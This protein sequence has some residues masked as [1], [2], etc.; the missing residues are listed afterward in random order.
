MINKS[1]PLFKMLDF[2]KD[3]AD[4]AGIL[5]LKY[6]QNGLNVKFKY[7]NSPVTIADKEINSL[8]IT[9]IKEQY[10]DHSIIGEEASHILKKASYTWVCDPIDGNSYRLIWS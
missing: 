3:I 8:V 6:L 10:P 5:M 2:A 7:D 4:E 9:R 1:E